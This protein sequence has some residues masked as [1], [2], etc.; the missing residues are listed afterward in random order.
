MITQAL[1]DMGIG[2]Y[3]RFRGFQGGP[4][5]PCHDPWGWGTFPGLAESDPT[6]EDPVFSGIEGISQHPGLRPARHRG[7]H[8]R[9]QVRLGGICRMAD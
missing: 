1:K 7:K 4:T 8:R 5:D 6:I 9:S 3:S 2:F